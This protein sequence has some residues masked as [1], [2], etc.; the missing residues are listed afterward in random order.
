[1][2]TVTRGTPVGTV[3]TLS[4]SGPPAIQDSLFERTFEL[5][6]GTHIFAGNTVAQA[7][8]GNGTY[9]R[10]LADLASARQSITMQM[11]YSLPGKVADTIAS[12]LKERA[13][14]K[15]RVLL[16]IDAFGSQHMS[17]A[18]VKSLR[19]AGVEVARLRAL[20]WF[21]IHDAGDRSHVRVVVVDGRVG[22]TGG[23]GLADYWLGDGHHD[24]QWRE[25]NVRFEGPA[26][27]ELQAAFAAAWAESTGELLTGPLFFP[28][29]GFQPSGTTHAGLLYAAPTTG[30]TPAE[31][32][33]ALTLSGARKSLYITNSYFV[34]DD[35]FRRLLERAVKRGVDVR[36]LTVSSKTDVKTTWYA[37]RYRYEELLKNGVK[38]YE[39]QPTMLHAKTIVA[40][41][42]WSSIGSMNFDNRSMA[43]NNESNLVVL[44]SAFGE[45][46]DSVFF[47]D[48]RYSKQIVLSE[49]QHRSVWSKILEACSA[50]LSRLL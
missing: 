45:S 18:W 1:V 10:L 19:D 34:P 9:P 8:N 17:H 43:F 33:L 11:Y 3:V 27:M 7:L 36:V 4:D 6:T 49:F 47:D 26:A 2:L 24:N 38:V 16:I 48:L 32:F 30:S 40:D 20:H 46:M 31:R 39:Y 28:S 22:Y 5:F 29:S 37:G 12:V 15:V 44:D 21:T 42:L 35:D 25:S 13:R 14:A 50:L 23:F 41:G